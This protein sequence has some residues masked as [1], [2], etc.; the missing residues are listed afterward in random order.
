MRIIGGK[1]KSSLLFNTKDK[2]TRPLKDITKE[3]IFNLITHSNKI[4]LKIEG[5]NVLD[6]Y[7]GTGSFGV[8]CLSRS[9]K[10]VNFIEQDKNAVE[11]LKK[12]IEKLKLKKKINIFLSD[13]FRIIKKKNIFNS[14]FDL[15]FCDPPFKNKNIKE[16]LHAILFSNLLKEKGIIIIHRS[17]NSQD[18]FPNFFKIVDSRSYGI[19]K[20]I[21]G[22]F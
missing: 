4:G 16:L 17:K 10:S 22:N 18:N 19:S 13:V 1:L 8:E 5:A 3:S 7:S 20:V 11:I 21:F 2:G 12:N 6:L 9:A 14:S 15:I